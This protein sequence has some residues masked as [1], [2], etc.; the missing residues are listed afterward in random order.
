MAGGPGGPPTGWSESQAER[1]LRSLELFGMRFGLD[2][3]RRMMTVLGSPER[4]FDT[5]HVVG[6]NGKTSTTRMIA[7]ILERHGVRTG[8]YLSPHLSSYCERV[9][10]SERDISPEGFTDAVARAADVLGVVP[11]DVSKTVV[12]ATVGGGRPLPAAQPDSA[13]HAADVL[14]RL[15]SRAATWNRRDI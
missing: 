9:Q 1:H 6:T 5:I 11:D 10:V 4:R 8:A 12:A 7:A 15:G 2:R 14:A 13:T 3:M